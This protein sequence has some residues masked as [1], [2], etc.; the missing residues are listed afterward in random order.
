MIWSL[1]LLSIILLISAHFL[2]QT[3]ESS[4]RLASNYWIVFYIFGYFLP[5]PVFLDGSDGWSTIW[6]FAFQDKEAAIQEAL[7]LAT[8]G[9]LLLAFCSRGIGR[10]QTKVYKA[11]FHAIQTRQSLADGISRFRLFILFAVVF[12]LLLL[13][14]HLLGGIWSLLQNL[15][16][17]ITLFAGLNALFLPLNTLIGACFAIS[18]A[19]AVNIKISRKI[20]IFAILTT[21][22]ALFL[23]GQKSNI[24]ILI[25]G[26][27]IIKFSTAKRIRLIPICV[28]AFLGVNFLLM[29]E[30]LFREAL[31]I[32]VDK[33][34]LTLE[35]WSNFLWTQVTG[36]FMQIQNL[37]VLIDAMPRELS[38]RIGDTYA[39]IFSLIMP[40]QFIGIKPLTAAG[41]NTLAFWP[42]VVA[43]ESTTMPPGVFGEAYMNFSWLGYLSLCVL[44]GLILRRIDKPWREGRDRTAMDIVWVAIAGSI[45]LHF[46]RGELF[47]PLLIV[48]GIYLGAKFTLS[49]QKK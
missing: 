42:E 29:Y 38:Y 17:R 7:L 30:F 16:D 8:L 46:I 28:V 35:G 6:G 44:I 11:H 43:R 14:I 22:P 26:T 48:A 23:L 3:Q 9:G 45:S 32:G 2:G 40:Q 20:E 31:I 36:N 18:S 34:K 24:L 39:A 25:L 10:I 47:S 1:A 21:L 41:V 27:A 33:E 15:G 49:R 5:I 37:T 4:V 12:S 13:G 19:R